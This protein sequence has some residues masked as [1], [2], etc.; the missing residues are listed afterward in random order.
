MI[1]QVADNPSWAS[2]TCWPFFMIMAKEWEG[3]LSLLF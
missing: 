1:R 2:P 3:W